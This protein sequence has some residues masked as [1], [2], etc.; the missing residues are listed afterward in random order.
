MRKTTKSAICI[1]FLSLFVL[2]CVPSVKASAAS[3]GTVD[4]DF[5]GAT[6]IIVS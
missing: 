3:K 1:M 4:M 2:L 6:R 5:T